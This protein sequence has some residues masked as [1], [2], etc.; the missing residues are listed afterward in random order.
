MNLFKFF[1]PTPED[2][3]VLVHGSDHKRFC[4]RHDRIATIGDGTG[5]TECLLGVHLHD[6]SVRPF[7]QIPW[8]LTEMWIELRE[9]KV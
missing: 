6:C 2:I 5:A 4:L 1:R 7:I 3:P 8:D 9:G